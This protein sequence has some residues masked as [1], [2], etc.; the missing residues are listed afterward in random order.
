MAHPKHNHNLWVTGPI[1]KIIVIVYYIEIYN[2]LNLDKVAANCRSAEPPPALCSMVTCRRKWKQLGR[3]RVWV[4]AK[5]AP[6]IGAPHFLKNPL[7]PRAWHAT[8]YKMDWGFEKSD[9]KASVGIDLGS[10]IFVG[11]ERAMHCGKGGLH[12]HNGTI[13]QS[14]QC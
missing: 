12:N 11:G 5:P 14:I 9:C 6:S 10:H 8:Q 4:L 13:C 1:R 7:D 2:Q 3:A